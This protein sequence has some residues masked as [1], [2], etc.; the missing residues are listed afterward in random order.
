MDVF[1]ARQP[2]FDGA[3]R[4]YGYELLFR[5]GMVDRFDGTD[6]DDATRRV[7]SAWM[8]SI[9]MERLTGDRKGFVNF[10]QNLLL[11]D[12]GAFLD[13]ERIVVEILETVEGTSAVVE[14][15]RDLRSRGFTIA[16][17]DFEDTP[18][19]RRLVEFADIVKIDFADCPMDRRAALARTYAASGITLLAEK[20]ETPE[21]LDE[22]KQLGF[23]LYQGHFFARPE[24]IKGRQLP[25]PKLHHL[26]IVQ[27]INTPQFRFDQ[28]AE[29]V[30]R[31]ASLSYR[32][33][34]YI[35][36]AAFGWRTRVRSIQH[37][38][39]LLGEREI[40][41]W[42]TLAALGSVAEDRP[43]ELITSAVVRGRLCEMLAER[44]RLPDRTMDLF[45]LGM[46]SRFDAIVGRPMAEV[47]ETVDLPDDVRDALIDPNTPGR[48]RDLLDAVVA[49]EEA[50]WDTVTAWCRETRIKRDTMSALYVEA[51]EWSEALQRSKW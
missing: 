10:T 23:E 49:Y 5:R 42:A 37:A 51:V 48:L 36:S 30:H 12:P 14:A 39:V 50:E 4:T 38:L 11:D 22:A 21:E 28:L 41:R 9:G 3:L 46:L 26:R 45:F 33:M 6:G 40:R 25:I 15:C 19:Q 31:D 17:D 47:L 8:F 34:R 29:V 1:V 20:V 13:P 27:E 18:A 2:I 43:Q 35:N 16:L 44:I 24:T 32:L 7:V